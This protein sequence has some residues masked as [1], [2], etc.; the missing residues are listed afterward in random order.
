MCMY[1]AT[2]ERTNSYSWSDISK[3]L[4]IRTDDTIF[5]EKVFS[6]FLKEANH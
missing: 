4:N 1:K 3:H 6:S 5:G 2:H